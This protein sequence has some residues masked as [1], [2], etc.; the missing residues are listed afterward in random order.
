M[1][2]RSCRVT[3]TDSGTEDRQGRRLFYQEEWVSRPVSL[4]RTTGGGTLL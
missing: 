4:A 3:L 1:N 2:D